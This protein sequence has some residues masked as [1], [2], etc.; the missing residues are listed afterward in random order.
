MSR[1]KKGLLSLLSGLALLMMLGPVDDS[2]AGD[3]S[4]KQ[5]AGSMFQDFFG[6][7]SLMGS[8][9][10]DV[11]SGCE[12]SST[13]K[14]GVYQDRSG[15]R[16]S[17]GSGG[18]FLWLAPTGVQVFGTV[19]TARLNDANDMKASLVGFSDHG[20]EIFLDEGRVHDGESRAMRWTNRAA[21]RNLISVRLYCFRADGCA[22]NAGGPKAYFELS[23]IEF[24]S[25]DV[26]PPE[27]Q[28]AGTLQGLGESWAWHRGE[29]N[30]LVNATDEG[31]GVTRSFLLVNGLELGLD[32]VDCPGDFSTYVT[33]FTPCP[34][35]VGRFGVANTGQA[36]FQEGVNLFQFCAEDYAAASSEA[37]R[38]CTPIRFAFVDNVAPGSPEQLVT[39]GGSGWRSQNGFEM[40][41]T[42]PA[43]Q[44]SPIA[45]AQYRVIDNADGTE[46]ESGTV[47]LGDSPRL[48]P[49]DM[50]QAGEF[51]VEV[52]LKD[53]AGNL[54][55]PSSTTVRFDDGRPGDV[56]PEELA[57]WVS[58]DELPLSQVIE[59]AE[60]GGPSGVA[61]YAVTVSDS[62]PL[63]PCP[64]GQCLP[65][66]L[67]L[68]AG[69]DTRSMTINHL[70]EGDH[71]ISAVASSGAGLAS[72]TPGSTMARVDK[73]EPST[74]LSG[75]PQG[76]SKDPVTVTAVASDD[77]SGMVARPGMDD[78]FPVTVIRA[79][80]NPAFVSPGPSAT[81]TIADQGITRVDYWARDLAG[82][83]N[84]GA[85]TSDGDSHQRPGEA[86]VK[87]D[88]RPPSVEVEILSDPDDPELVKARV[89][90]ADSGVGT[91]SISYRRAGGD[92]DFIDLETRRDGST[93]IAHVPS[94]NLPAGSYE[95]QAT[96]VDLAGN[97]ATSTEAGQVYQLDLPLKKAT[98]VSLGFAGK[99]TGMQT[100]KV[101]Q[102]RSVRVGGNVTGH[103][104]TGLAGMKLVVEQRF[105]K[106][107]KAETGSDT[108][109]TGPSGKF[110]ALL[111]PGPSRK[112]NVRFAGNR[113]Q[114]PSISR[115]L[116]TVSR[117]RITYRVTP[118]VLRNGG[119]V[120]MTGKVIGKGAAR[121]KR[122]K[123]VA[124]Q[125]FDPARSR[126][127]P[128]EV[129]RCNRRGRF[130]YSYRFRT[131]SYTQK[132]LFRAV[133]LP[134]AGWPFKPST[135][136]RRS[137]IVY[138]HG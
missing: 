24:K 114:Q 70:S 81:F 17:T 103:D 102:G 123:L 23:D 117:D 3:Y 82:N 5:C 84:D 132:I 62:S 85:I 98:Q 110:T 8:D 2:Y 107:S 74:T 28:A 122:G 77:G 121:P 26:L 80:D 108:V 50:P 68:S 69:P 111:K 11:V 137:V 109:E 51:R 73:T 57:G 64:G 32:E 130:S 134:E 30:F 99:A 106:G 10:V 33:S 36:P 16:T 12:G 52:R 104:G 138:P 45:A 100:I 29:V 9:H 78:G 47:Q 14:V 15:T 56:A 35:Q 86:I 83:V 20:S 136:K 128:V 37:N 49:L 7:Y 46:V 97:E 116:Q 79:G 31:S 66:D 93:M 90:D 91:G 76:W 19:A 55:S 131:I 94:D 89:H 48:G 27:V 71:W 60:S 43:G 40:S 72:A 38:T 54:G 44:S 101:K 53:S 118:G 133:S 105:E 42:N 6:R 65:V 41:W 119:T 129:L 34:L 92:L 13:G 21:P 22:N 113:S 96:A 124:I 67:S 112:V 115:E 58:E 18:Q 4:V 120:R 25:S 75:I 59:R 135:S 127:R 88:R 126:W 39:T 63:L 125:Y 87:I 1:V 95:V 61:G